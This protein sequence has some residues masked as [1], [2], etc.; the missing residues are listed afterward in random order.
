MA[1][2]NRFEQG[3][4]VRMEV[5]GEEYVNKSLKNA[6]DFTRP[7]QELVSE[8]CWGTVWSRPGLD[9]R[10]R[11]LMNI[12]MLTALNHHNELAVHVRGALRNGVTVTEIQEAI[13]QAAIYC[14]VPAAL[15]AFRTAGSALV[16]MGVELS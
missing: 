8:Y 6:T 10:S 2:T 13:L 11:S 15:A 12:A 7:M 5:L 9:R 4:K 1:D 16:D 3:V 14:G